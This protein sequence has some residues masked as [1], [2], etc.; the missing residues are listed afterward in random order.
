[1]SGW[2][3]PGILLPWLI[4]VG[5][6]VTF[7]II[8]CIFFCYS[9][10]H[11]EESTVYKPHD[12]LDGRPKTGDDIEMDT[13]SHT[14][15]AEAGHSMETSMGVEEA[16]TK[17]TPRVLRGL[18]SPQERLMEGVQG[19][20]S[21]KDKVLSGSRGGQSSWAYVNLAYEKDVDL[22]LSPET[23]K[24]RREERM[25]REEKLGDEMGGRKDER[26]GKKAKGLGRTESGGKTEGRGARQKVEMKTFGRGW[27]TR[28]GERR[29]D[30]AGDKSYGTMKIKKTWAT[31]KS[32]PLSKEERSEDKQAEGFERS[33][34]LRGYENLSRDEG[35]GSG[36]FRL[37]DLRR[38]WERV[39]WRKGRR[40]S[41]SSKT[42]EGSLAG[43]E[44]EGEKVSPR[45]SETEDVRSGSGRRHS[46][47]VP[48]LPLSSHYSSSTKLLLSH[49]DEDVEER[50]GAASASSHATVA[51]REDSKEGLREGQISFFAHGKKRDFKVFSGN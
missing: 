31:S 48:V 16:D 11:E 45:D 30:R 13:F 42:S 38:E 32:W 29:S 18:P 49:E 15:T 47:R 22:I 14:S 5:F 35:D 17:R 6:I 4:V 21:L 19:R 34:I 28:G 20:A 10:K 51:Q 7:F 1:M 9:I 23:L 26:E 33:Q 37:K 2:F 3:A 40:E 50:S 25:A 39:S 12:V 36:V 43:S 24:R 41:G 44:P 8:F 27:E 46:P